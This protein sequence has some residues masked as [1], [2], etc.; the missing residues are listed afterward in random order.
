MCQRYE[1]PARPSLGCWRSERP[2]GSP[3]RA[4][5]SKLACLRTRERGDGPVTT[6]FDVSSVPFQGGYVAKQ[7][8]VRA[9]NDVIVPGE[10]LPP[11]L[12]QLT[13]A[14]FS[15]TDGLGA[16]PTVSV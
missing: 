15:D 2:A 10:P 5:A 8:P 7:C 3:R 9:Q 1:G 6:H 14:L 11:T 4:T 12:F 13:F 16:P